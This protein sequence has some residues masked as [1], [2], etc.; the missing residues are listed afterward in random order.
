MGM[1][2]DI[3]LVLNVGN[4]VRTNASFRS[5]E[6]GNFL[7][8]ILNEVPVNAHCGVLAVAWPVFE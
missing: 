5:V 7:E 1:P 4:L 2:N 3:G 8:T 6:T